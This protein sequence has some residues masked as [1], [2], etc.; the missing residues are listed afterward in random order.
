MASFKVD[1]SALKRLAERMNAPELS[2][3]INRIPQ[4][5]GVAALVSQAIADNF[6]KEGPGWAPLKAATIRRSLA[7]K[8]RRSLSQ[9]TDKEIIKHEK[10][11]RKDGGS[12]YRMIL[13][14]TGLLRKSVTVPSAQGNVYKVE[15]NNLIWGTDLVY[16]ATHNK[17][18]PKQNIPKREFLVI[19]KDWM[20]KIYSFVLGKY[21][22]IV[23]RAINGR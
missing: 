21:S 17:G 3:H 8:M 20:D 13:Q 19:K 2:E 12:T 1:L 15:G 16:A 22:E 23:S 4:E 11:A 7:K 18:N 14:K 10:A 9:M 6:N 5:K